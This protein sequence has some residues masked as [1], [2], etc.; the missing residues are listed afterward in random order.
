M[1]ENLA[2]SGIVG[3]IVEQTFH[4]IDLAVDLV[5]ALGDHRKSRTGINIISP[6]SLGTN[7]PTNLFSKL[8]K[9]PGVCGF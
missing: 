5:T 1:R 6:V 7:L 9:L 8:Q 4:P 3:S 2:K